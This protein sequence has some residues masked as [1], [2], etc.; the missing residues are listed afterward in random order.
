MIFSE[1]RCTLFRI[2]LQ[3]KLPSGRCRDF[4][5]DFRHVAVVP[6]D[7]FCVSC[8]EEKHT[9]TALASIAM[10]RERLPI[11]VPTPA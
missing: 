8:G 11:R 9:A 4:R 5:N 3:L 10:M 7:V 1:N 6:A 2:M